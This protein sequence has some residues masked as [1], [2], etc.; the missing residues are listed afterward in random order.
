MAPRYRLLGREKCFFPFRDYVLCMIFYL[1]PSRNQYLELTFSVLTIS[2]SIYLVGDSF[3]WPSLP[4][5]QPSRSR[6]AQHS[7]LA[8]FVACVA[9]RSLTK[10]ACHQHVLWTPPFKIFLPVFRRLPR[11][12][13]TTLLLRSMVFFILFR[14]QAPLFLL[15]L[16]SSL[17][18][19]W[20]SRARSSRR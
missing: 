16:A 19:S 3:V 11:P 2:S 17:G 4:L 9:L 7:S 1:L 15:G 8:A 13:S 14:L 18:T 20:T 10:I 5:W 12:P 6:P